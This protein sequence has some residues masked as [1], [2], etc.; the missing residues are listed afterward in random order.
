MKLKGSLRALEAFT[1]SFASRPI[2]FIQR[3]VSV[4]KCSFTVLLHHA[5]VLGGNAV[6]VIGVS[7]RH[8]RCFFHSARLWIL[9]LHESSSSL[10]SGSRASQHYC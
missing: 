1:T 3:I 7:I 2:R 6:I 10:A 8:N 9:I 5:P 4:S